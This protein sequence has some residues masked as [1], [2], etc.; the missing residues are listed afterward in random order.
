VEL[1]DIV[2]LRSA[3]E[4]KDY[5]LPLGTATG[6]KANPHDAHGMNK[7]GIRDVND[8]NALREPCTR[9]QCAAK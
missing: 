8:V 6:E 9:P 3:S 1:G 7:D 2:M 4:E 5:V